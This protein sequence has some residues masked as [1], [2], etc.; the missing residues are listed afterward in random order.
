MLNRGERGTTSSTP[1]GGLWLPKRAIGLA[2]VSILVILIYMN[3][4]SS[5]THVRSAHHDIVSTTTTTKPKP[6]TISPPLASNDDIA[7]SNG[8]D[9]ESS[10]YDTGLKSVPS[11]SSSESES[12]SSSSSSTKSESD[13]LASTLPSVILTPTDALDLCHG[14]T[15][16][17]AV[18]DAIFPTFIRWTDDLRLHHH[19]TPC[20]ILVYDLSLSHEHVTQLDKHSGLAGSAVYRIPLPLPWQS[21]KNPDGLPLPTTNLEVLRPW[22]IRSSL[23]LLYHTNESVWRS[24]HHIHDVITLST[25]TQWPSQVLWLDPNVNAPSDIHM[26]AIS[27]AIAKN[28][29]W[30]P[31]SGLTS[32]HLY[33]MTMLLSHLC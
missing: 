18:W 13:G 9:L 29:T 10:S 21:L 23:D 1:S 32:I 28:F 4:S 16:L 27:K 19:V 25:L 3:S 15:L 14:V 24:Q 17:T 7:A 26:I 8:D 6:T 12:E 11:S 33:Q 22:L 31:H 2:C 20:P 5:T 30:I